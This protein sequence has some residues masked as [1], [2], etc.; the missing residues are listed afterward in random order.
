MILHKLT[1][2][3]V[4]LF[5]GEQT[6]DLTPNGAGTYNPHRWDERCWQDDT[7]GCSSSLFVWQTS[8]R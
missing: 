8:T 7:A 4:G 5:R 6:L 3:N 2:N 1:L